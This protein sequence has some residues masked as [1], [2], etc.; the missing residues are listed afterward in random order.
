M[1]EKDAKELEKE[2]ADD[3]MV[4][5]IIENDHSNIVSRPPNSRALRVQTF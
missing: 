2:M 1:T 4:F 3:T 5:C